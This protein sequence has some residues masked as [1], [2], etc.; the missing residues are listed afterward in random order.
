MVSQDGRDALLG[1]GDF[2]LYDSTRPYQLQFD[3]D[4]QQFV[5]KLPG[6]TLRTRAARHRAAHRHAR[7][8]ATAAPAT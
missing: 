6:P 4:F 3:D 8:A 7:C 5:L 1:P 2:A